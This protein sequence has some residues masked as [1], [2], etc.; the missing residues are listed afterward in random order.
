METKVFTWKI[1]GWRKQEKKI[2]SETFSCGG[3]DWLECS[4]CVLR[5]LLMRPSRRL[6]LFPRG[7]HGAKMSPEGNFSLYLDYVPSEGAKT[8]ACAQFALVVTNAS[9]PKNYEVSRTSVAA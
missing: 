8:F 6:L 2:Y 5:P 9:D 7:N 4:Y 1:T 3:F